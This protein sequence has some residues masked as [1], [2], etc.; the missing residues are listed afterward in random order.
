MTS[1]EMEQRIQR[2]E[3]L[4]ETLYRRLEMSEPPNR[5]PD[6]LAPVRELV[7]RGKKIQAIKVYREVTGVGLKEA[8]EAVERM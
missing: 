6:H 7:Q 4:V 3:E 5:Q 8:K 2:L 1:F